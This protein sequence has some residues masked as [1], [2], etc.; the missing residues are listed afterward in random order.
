MSHKEVGLTFS[1]FP[2]VV[3]LKSLDYF[4]E[5]LPSFFD[6]NDPPNFAGFSVFYF[7]VGF[8]FLHIASIGFVEEF[9]TNVGQLLVDVLIP[10]SSFIRFAKDS[11]LKLQN[12]RE[13]SS[14]SFYSF[15][16]LFFG[17][18]FHLVG[19]FVEHSRE[20]NFLGGFMLTCPCP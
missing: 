15:Q 20:W 8:N 2:N 13:P 17:L 5:V 16:V 12:S 6:V 1:D 14:L 3:F 7:V 4:V 9:S 19:M 18:G 10:T 11:I